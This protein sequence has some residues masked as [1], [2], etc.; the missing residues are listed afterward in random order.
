MNLILM[1]LRGSGKT[2]VGRLMAERVGRVFV[3]LDDVTPRRLGVST[4]REAWDRFGQPAFREAEA[5]A[6]AEQL[7]ADGL[8]LSLGGGTPTA[9][10]AADMLRQAASRDRVV[11]LRASPR[12][13]RNRLAATE[14]GSRPAITGGDPLDEMERVWTARDPLYR[15][16]AGEIIDVDDLTPEETLRRLAAVL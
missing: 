10:G 13:L 11:Y 9:P 8:V 1:G 3:D 7:A 5:A 12:G 6:L 15:E 14:M 16:L 4:V 2:T